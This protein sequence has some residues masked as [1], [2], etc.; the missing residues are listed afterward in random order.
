MS[1]RYHRGGTYQTAN[2]RAEASPLRSMSLFRPAALVFGPAW[3]DGTWSQP[4]VPSTVQVAPDVPAP[5]DAN[6]ELANA[7][8][9]LR[10][11]VRVYDAARAGIGEANRTSLPDTLPAFI[12]K[13][14]EASGGAAPIRRLT[15]ERIRARKSAAFRLFNQRRRELHAARRRVAAARAALG[16]PSLAEIEGR[17]V[18]ATE[19]R[20]SKR[21]PVRPI[22]SAAVHAA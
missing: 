22:A 15:P 16:L 5:V 10:D 9:A 3:H 7:E 12:R 19:L 18:I 2:P 11:A 1:Q 13:Q 6:R 17:Q 14:I 21:R 8:A 4:K 20:A